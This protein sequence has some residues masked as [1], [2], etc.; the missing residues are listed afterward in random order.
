MPAADSLVAVNGR[1]Y[2]RPS[3]PT[4]VMTIDGCQPSYLDDAMVRG[5]MP[6][7]AAMLA[8][9]G[10][11]HLGSGVMP[12]VGLRRRDRP[13]FTSENTVGPRPGVTGGTAAKGGGKEERG[14]GE[15]RDRYQLCSHYR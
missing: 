1:D 14:K 10:A 13:C 5:L 12:S 9:E 4:V 8:G 6:R 7:L 11:Y 2:R 15:R 3:R